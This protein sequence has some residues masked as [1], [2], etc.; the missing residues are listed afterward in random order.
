[1]GMRIRGF[2]RTRGRGS[3]LWSDG[4]HYKGDKFREWT[5]IGFVRRGL[6]RIRAHYRGK[7]TRQHVIDKRTRKGDYKGK[8]CAQRKERGRGSPW[9]FSR[10]K[11]I[12]RMGRDPDYKALIRKI[13][14]TKVSEMA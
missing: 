5:R 4:V 8:D 6:V 10:G 14:L 1:M 7:G 12:G 3:V 11:E 2:K 9:K 13:E